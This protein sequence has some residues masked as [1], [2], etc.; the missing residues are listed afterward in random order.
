MA[1]DISEALCKIDEQIADVN[2]DL[3]LFSTDEMR[4]RVADMYSAIFNYLAKV[5]TWLTQKKLKRLTSSFNDKLREEYQGALDDVKAKSDRIKSYA[6]QGTQKAIKVGFETTWKDRRAADARV[7]ARLD[8]IERHN[9]DHAQAVLQL[10]HNLTLL[11]KS[12]SSRYLD[13][14]QTRD[15]RRIMSRSTSPSIFSIE[16]GE[17]P[18]WR[19]AVI[20][21][22]VLA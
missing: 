17:N 8:R 1:E 6:T 2:V 7:A 14:H 19:H 13:E 15:V 16:D 21:C 5:S 4:R 9:A 10:G 20:T 11:L 22:R 18:S 3:E 12:Q